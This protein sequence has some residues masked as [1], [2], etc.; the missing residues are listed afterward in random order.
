MKTYNF[1]VRTLHALC[2]VLALA[3]L[4]AGLQSIFVANAGTP[5]GAPTVF[6]GHAIGKMVCGFVLL[7]CAWFDALEN[8]LPDA[9]CRNTATYSYSETKADAKRI[10]DQAVELLKMAYSKDMARSVTSKETP[11]TGSGTSCTS[12]AT[13]GL[14]ESH[15]ARLE[16]LAMPCLSH[17]VLPPDNR[18]TPAEAGARLREAIDALLTPSA[19][20]SKVSTPGEIVKAAFEQT[21]TT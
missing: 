9:S 13:H 12:G 1:N 3:L 11:L 19:A 14:A 4:V 2:F 15:R 8:Q 16:E 5:A 6:P 7:A 10:V 17:A 18:F 21:Q 20:A